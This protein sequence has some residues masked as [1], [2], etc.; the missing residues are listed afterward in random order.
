VKI[1]NETDYRTEDLRRFII[2]AHE[3]TATEM[4]EWKV[5]R[6]VWSK[7]NVHWG[8]AYYDNSGMTLTIPKGKL[9]MAELARVTEHELAHN[10]GI[11]HGDMDAELMHRRMAD[12]SPFQWTLP[13]WAEGIELRLVD[14]KT[15]PTMQERVDLR[16]A[17]AA[18]MALLWERKLATAKK[19]VKKW[20]TK[21]RYYATRGPVA[22]R[23]VT[24]RPSKVVDP[25]E[26]NIVLRGEPAGEFRALIMDLASE[27][28]ESDRIAMARWLDT[29]STR[30]GYRFKVTDDCLGQVLE[31]ESE[32]DY[33]QHHNEVT[34]RSFPRILAKVVMARK[35]FQATE[36]KSTPTEG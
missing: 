17:H 35:A 33:W 22:A 26:V 2:I 36:A 16:A 11:K 34:G 8:C 12:G 3:A 4:P 14:R 30:G 27:S 29:A 15:A 20:Q 10:R 24:G 25:L 31:L 19:R 13:G 5:V 18:K 6:V 1:V 32:L 28:S 9:S 7:H 23:P 21:V